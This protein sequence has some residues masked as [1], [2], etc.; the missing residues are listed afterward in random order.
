MGLM[1]GLLGGF[2]TFSSFA[3]EAFRLASEG[4]WA[5]AVA[6]VGLTNACGLA[7][8]WGAYR[9]VGAL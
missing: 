7:G 2:T 1:A 4:E 8:V 6:Y 5:A 9:I 3:L